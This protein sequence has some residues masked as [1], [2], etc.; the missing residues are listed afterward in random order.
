MSALGE[1]QA[2]AVQQ[3]TSGLPAGADM[4]GALADVCFAPKA[5]SC[6]GTN[7]RRVA[8]ERLRGNLRAQ[9]D[10]SRFFRLIDSAACQQ[11]GSKPSPI[12]AM[13]L[14]EPVCDFHYFHDFDLIPIRSLARIFPYQ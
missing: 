7:G 1:Q 5:D 12:N 9:T 13:I 10:S 11:L 14:N 2:C 8:L 3:R 6:T 4:C